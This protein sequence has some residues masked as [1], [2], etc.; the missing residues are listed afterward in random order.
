MLLFHG[1]LKN[2]STEGAVALKKF[3]SP[4]VHTTGLES[5]VHLLSQDSLN[6]GL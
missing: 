2:I 1:G 6:R 5:T 3:E 4:D